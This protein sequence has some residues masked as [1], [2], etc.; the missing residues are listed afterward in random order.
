MSSLTSLHHSYVSSLPFPPPCST[1]TVIDA[2]LAFD[3]IRIPPHGYG[4]NSETLPT[5]LLNVGWLLPAHFEI[6]WPWPRFAFNASAVPALGSLR[7]TIAGAAFVKYNGINS[8]D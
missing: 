3:Y 1:G 4:K 6:A 8:I 7:H 2:Y 5:V